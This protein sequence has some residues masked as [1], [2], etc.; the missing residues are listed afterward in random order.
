[1][2]AP[3]A[4]GTISPNPMMTRYPFG[5]AAYTSVQMIH[6]PN[7]ISKTSRILCRRIVCHF[8]SP[9]FLVSLFHLAMKTDK[10]C[11]KSRQGS[12]YGCNAYR[13]G[14]R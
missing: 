13:P 11:Y 9:C 6:P 4:D 10:P 5:D 3:L 8:T 1:M 2:I 7:P 12:Y 14:K